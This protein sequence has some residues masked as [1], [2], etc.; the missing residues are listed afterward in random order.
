MCFHLISSS[1]VDQRHQNSGIY[2][3][4]LD[5]DFDKLTAKPLSQ[6]TFTVSRLLKFKD[7]HC[8][9]YISCLQITRTGIYFNWPPSAEIMRSRHHPSLQI[10]HDQDLEELAM[11]VEDDGPLEDIPVEM[12]IED[13]GPLED[14]PVEMDI[15]QDD[16]NPAFQGKH[17]IF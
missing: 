7:S 4:P 15:D 11:V 5:V 9:E 13:D 16:P 1:L 8:L 6:P 17:S 2:L 14:I 12:E 10:V 3:I